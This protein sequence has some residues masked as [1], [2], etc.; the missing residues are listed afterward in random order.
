[1]TNKQKKDLIA[2]LL[3]DIKTLKTDEALAE[4][5]IKVIEIIRPYRELFNDD[6]KSK[7]VEYI[8]VHKAAVNGYPGG[9]NVYKLIKPLNVLISDTLEEMYA[10]LA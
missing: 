1:M 4:R 9:E 5:L 7:V 10:E 3:I 8:K 2:N 6:I